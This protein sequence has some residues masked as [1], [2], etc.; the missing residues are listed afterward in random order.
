MI[1]D[2]LFNETIEVEPLE[3]SSSVG[4]VFGEKV[5]ERVRFDGKRRRVT[6]ADGQE[7]ISSGTILTRPDG[8]MDMGARVTRQGRTYTV[9]E[10][11]PAPALTGVHHLE[12]LVS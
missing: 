9:I 2:I 6:S 10:V 1:P 12:V 4:P 3:G 11:L 8:A 5:K 7:I